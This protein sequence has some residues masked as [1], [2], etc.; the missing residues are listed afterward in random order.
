MAVETPV[1]PTKKPT[2]GTG[3]GTGYGFK[4]VLWNCNCHTFDDVAMA[5]MLAIRCSM[6]KGYTLAQNVHSNGKTIVY[7]GHRERCEAVAEVLQGARLRVTLE[8]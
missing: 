4:V 7:E 2:D 6:E 1:K 8:Q 5:L 3:R